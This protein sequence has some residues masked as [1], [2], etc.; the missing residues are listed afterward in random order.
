MTEEVKL[1][2]FRELH[3]ALGQ[4]PKATERAVLRRIATKALE[5][6]R[7]QARQL[8]PVDEGNL[9]DS[10]TIGTK[11][12]RNARKAARA[13][14][15]DGVRVFMGTSNRNGVPRE[16]GSW[17]TAAQPFMRPAWH[18]GKRAALAFIMT[19]L[20]GEIARTATRLAKRAAKKKG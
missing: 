14:P 5:P 19:E 17:R 15:V 11:L 4:L 13:D 3:D 8:V 12:N 1:E 9:R 6:M 16:Y 18:T 10:I 20:G 2:G 7:D